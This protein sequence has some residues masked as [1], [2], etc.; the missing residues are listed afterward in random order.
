MSEPHISESA[1]AALGTPSFVEVISFEGI[2][3]TIKADLIARWPDFNVQNLESDPAVKLLEVVAYREMQYR[4]R[5]ND[6][7]RSLLVAYGVGSDLDHIGSFYDA[8]RLVNESDDRFR[9]RIILAIQGRSPGGTVARYKY[10]ALSSSVKVRSVAVWREDTD[11]TI[12]VSVLSTDDGG[13][14]SNNLLNIVEAAMNDDTVRMVSDTIVVESAVQ[15]TVNIAADIWLLPD[16][17]VAVFNALEQNLRDAWELEG[18][19]G[20]DLSRSWII[21]RLMRGGVQKV[22]VG[23]PGSDQTAPFNKA[24]SLGTI[25]LTLAGRNF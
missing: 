10:I 21:S 6:A 22:S 9:A 25:T 1:V 17:P 14:P 2:L 15:Q 23:T 5:V 18:G 24:I 19:L 8:V 3:S 4:Q 13:V 11:P 20:F 12:R 16:T 7:A